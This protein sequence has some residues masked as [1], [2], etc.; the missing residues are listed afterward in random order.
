LGDKNRECTYTPLKV[1][2]YRSRVSGPLL[3]RIDI[4]VDVP[5]VKY[6]ELIGESMGES[7]QPIRR[8]VNMARKIQLK[9][10]SNMEI[11]SNSQMTPHGWSES[12]LSP[13]ARDLGCLRLR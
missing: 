9:S 8:R 6:K 3:D 7:S 1:E 2:K 13:I 5:P 4:H 11:H 10:F 12:T